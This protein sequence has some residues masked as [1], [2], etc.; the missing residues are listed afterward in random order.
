MNYE[1]MILAVTRLW[2]KGPVCVF[3]V[4][5]VFAVVKPGT[6]ECVEIEQMKGSVLIGTYQRPY[7]EAHAHTYI[8]EDLNA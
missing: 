4:R 3:K 1:A 2:S 6:P 8:L 5:D 7:R